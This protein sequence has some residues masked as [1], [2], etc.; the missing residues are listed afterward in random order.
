[1]EKMIKKQEQNQTII[2]GLIPLGREQAISL[3]ELAKSAGM[4]KRGV[5]TL[6]KLLRLDGVPICSSSV[7]PFT[8]YYLPVS[9][10]ELDE[11]LRETKGRANELKKIASSVEMGYLHSRFI[12]E[13]R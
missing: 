10:A 2:K 12:G 7:I 9:E 1:M 6:I 8:G 11:Y 5:R 3:N 13:I 4:S